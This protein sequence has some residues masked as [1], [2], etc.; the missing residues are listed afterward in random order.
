M[1]QYV[2]VMCIPS[3]AFNSRIER[4]KRRFAAN[5]AQEAAAQEASSDHKEPG[6]SAVPVKGGGKRARSPRPKLKGKVQ[7]TFCPTGSHLTIE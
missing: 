3:T 2:S 7:L 5:A 1:D 6:P 4:E